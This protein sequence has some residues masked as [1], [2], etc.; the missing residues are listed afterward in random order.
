MWGAVLNEAIVQNRCRVTWNGIAK[1]GH[2]SGPGFSIF[3][4]KCVEMFYVFVSRSV[5]GGQ[6]APD[7]Q[8][9]ECGAQDF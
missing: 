8:S 7:G 6:C 5:A 2:E 9:A 1:P 3:K 4:V